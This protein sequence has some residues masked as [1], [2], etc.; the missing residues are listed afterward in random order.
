MASRGLP[1]LDSLLIVPI[2]RLPRYRLLL[3]ALLGLT[4]DV[5]V[6]KA[7]LQD[8]L[9]EVCKAVKSVNEG[10]AVAERM[11][12][13]LELDELIY[14]LPQVRKKIFLSFF[15]FFSFF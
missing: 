12:Q 5:H 7:S 9:D 13:L 3:E 10:K 1:P 15:F 8:A 4:D 11:Q 2:Q 6:D 14:N